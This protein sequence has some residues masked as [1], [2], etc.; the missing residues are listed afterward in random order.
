[1]PSRQPTNDRNTI[2]S[3]TFSDDI[4]SPKQINIQKYVCQYLIYDI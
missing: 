2:D 3:F 4:E 1:M